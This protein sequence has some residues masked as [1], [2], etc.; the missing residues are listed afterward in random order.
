MKVKP[1]RADGDVA[2][3]P[4]TKGFEAVIDVAD[5]PLVAG[6]NWYVHIPRNGAAYARRTLNGCTPSEIRMHRVIAGCP[7]GMLVDHKDGNGLNN[8]RSNLR[9]ADHAQNSHNARISSANTSGFKGATFHK[10]TGKW[11]ANIWFDKKRIFLGC[12][13]SPGE[14]HKAYVAASEFFH[15]EFGRAA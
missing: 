7:D 13:R 8:R 12:F 9:I 1:V 6:H 15:G 4:L 11:H 2:Y 3:V 14:A 10:G 5:I